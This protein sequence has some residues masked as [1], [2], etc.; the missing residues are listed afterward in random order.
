MNEYIL[1]DDVSIFQALQKL[2]T[3]PGS[4][5]TLLI[6]NKENQVVGTLT[7]GDIRRALLKGM[8]LNHSVLE[9]IHSAFKFVRPEDGVEQIKKYRN[10]HIKLIPVLATNGEL[11]DIINL[12]TH[13]SRLP[14]DAVLMAGGKG[15]RLRPL[16][17]DIPKP[18]LP[19]GGKAIIDYNVERLISY[20]I[21]DISVTVNY[22]AEQL[23][24]HFSEK[25]KG[26][27]VQT[28]REPKFLG[29]IGATQFVPMYH[30]DTILVMNSDLF[31]NIDFEDFY[32]HFKE[33]N[34]DLSVAAVPYSISIPYGIFELEGRNI[35]EV[36][37]KPVY[38]YFANAGIYLIKRELLD[39]MPKDVFYNATDLIEDA[40]QHSKNV[41]RYP[42]TGYWLD[43]GSHQEYNKA[44]DLVKHILEW[45]LK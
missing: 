17:N 33:H 5:K 2:E 21:K 13:Q 15:E 44:Q 42:I 8:G 20:G 4:I 14:I 7:D 6:L 3:Q 23:E 12:S 25:M 30:N 38:N 43:I 29:T 16:T 27:Q 34:A 22:L 40:I 32:L 10:E 11:V 19:V 35:K 24:E 9:I 31:T 37:E 1:Q 26:V 36:K 39:K 45:P 41:I 28:I 18:L